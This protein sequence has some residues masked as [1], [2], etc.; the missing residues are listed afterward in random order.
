MQITIFGAGS[1]GSLFAG[2]MAFSGFDSSV[3]G[4]PRHV[5]EIRKS[6]LRVINGKSQIL[7]HLPAHTHFQPGLIKPDVLFIT[8]KAYD[9]FQ[10]AEILQRQL[11]PGI[12]LV[13]IQNGMGNETAFMESLPNNPIFRAITTEAA[14][15]ITPGVVKHVAFGRTSFNGIT[16]DENGFKTD[17]KAILEKSGFQSRIARDIQL[18]MWQKLLANAAICPLAALLHVPNGLILEKPSN[19]RIF[20]ALLAEGLRLAKQ[21][22]PDAD[23]SQ[24]RQFILKVIKKT[25]NNKCSMLQ[26]IERG[27]RTEIDFLNGFIVQESKRRG[28]N[29]P[30]N[31]AVTNLVHQ[32]EP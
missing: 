18:T 20:D 19:Q 16:G 14:E 29:A 22:V 5:A 32:L 4:R 28:L 10:V 3:I 31:A 9:N 15:L 6:G 7:S 17:I 2:R 11:K 8:T 27:R 12:P 24:T 13:L 30:V 1:I 25:A 23:F 26:D 21:S